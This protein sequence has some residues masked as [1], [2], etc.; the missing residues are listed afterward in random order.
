MCGLTRAACS[1]FVAL[2]MN[3]RSRATGIATGDQAMFVTR[4]AFERPAA[5]RRSR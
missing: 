2:M 4:A 3:L 5:F 1:R